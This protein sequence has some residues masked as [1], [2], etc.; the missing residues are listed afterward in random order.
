MKGYATRVVHGNISRKDIHGSLRPPLYDSVAFEFE[1]SR[2]LELAFAG[3]KPSHAYSRITNPTVEEFEE[4]IRLLSNAFGVVAVSSGM[5]A[6]ANT[7]LALAKPNSNVVTS[8]HLFSHTLSLFEQTLGLWGLEVRFADMTTP[9]SVQASIDENTAL[10]FLEVISNP[11]LEIADVAAVCSV[12]A[13][14]NVPVVLDGTLTTPYLFHSKEAGVAVEVLSSTKYISGGATTIG[15]LIIDNGVFDWGMIAA[16]GD[17]AKKVGPGAFLMRLRKEVYRNTGA[18]LSAHN[19]WLQILGLE[20]LPLR[21]SRS[22]EN[23]LAAAR[24][25]STVSGVKRVNYPGLESSRWYAIAA[26]QFKRGFGGLLTFE[27]ESKEACFRMMDS[28]KIIRRATNLSDNKSLII[29]PGSTIYADFSA[30]QRIKMDI[31]DGLIRLSV[32]IE[33]IED[34]IEDLAQGLEKI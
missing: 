3:R 14:R 12:A 25:L 21:I 23:A 19:A 1:S 2:D 32:G 4:R 16:T 18:C 24:F 10:I 17:L 6:I 5:A 29:H 22:S 15:G 33:D 27:L 30:E 7:V 11:Q 26:R 8:K 9:E 31:S 20:T 28:L 34:I 13:K